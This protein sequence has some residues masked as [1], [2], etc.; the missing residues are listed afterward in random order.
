M[1]RGRFGPSIF[2]KRYMSLTMPCSPRHRLTAMKTLVVATIL[3]S[4]AM[5][6]CE[7]ATISGT[8]STYSAGKLE[9]LP[10]ARVI[11]SGPAMLG[12]RTTTTDARGRYYFCGVPAGASY[13][14]VGELEGF[15]PWP[16]TVEY[17]Y[18]D[19]AAAVT[20]PLDMTVHE[21]DL[22]REWQVETSSPLNSFRVHAEFPRWK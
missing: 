20:V 15:R 7:A 12:T 11:L 18:S 6:P 19:D 17:L 22:G 2:T 8:V 21:C 9:T 10:G 5:S 13:R 1:H 14:L 4:S 3:I 16:M